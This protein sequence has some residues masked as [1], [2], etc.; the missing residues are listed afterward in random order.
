M[1]T[2]A[3]STTIAWV[4]ATIA[5]LRQELLASRSSRSTD[6]PLSCLPACLNAGMP[7]EVGTARGTRPQIRFVQSFG[8]GSKTTWEAVLIGDAER[9]DELEPAAMLREMRGGRWWAGGEPIGEPIGE[10]RAAR[11]GHLASSAS[12]PSVAS[13]SS[14]SSLSSP[15]RRRERG[16]RGSPSAVRVGGGATHWRQ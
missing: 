15:G 12:T 7:A 3:T 10:W 8:D 16:D 5:P 2:A 14:S 1:Y 11:R 9:A 6:S 4:T 13:S